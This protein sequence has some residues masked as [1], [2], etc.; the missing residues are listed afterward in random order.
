MQSPN[1]AQLMETWARQ[2]GAYAL[3]IFQDYNAAAPRRKADNSWVTEVDETIEQMLREHIAQ[4]FPDDLIMGKR[5]A[6]KP[7][8]AGGFGCLIQLMALVRL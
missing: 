5:A 7:A 6:A 8:T 3:D 4:A 1:E 2:A